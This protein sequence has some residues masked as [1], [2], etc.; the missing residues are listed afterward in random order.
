MNKSKTAAKMRNEASSSNNSNR[1]GET[2][3]A[4]CGTCRSDCGY[5]KSPGGKTSNT[6]GL[7]AYSVTVDDYQG[8]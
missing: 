2:V 8:F 3:V 7:W 5:C 4:D 1:R 6:H